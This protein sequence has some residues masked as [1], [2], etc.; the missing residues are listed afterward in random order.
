MK[1]AAPRFAVE[2]VFAACIGAFGLLLLLQPGNASTY[3]ALNDIGGTLPPLIAGGIAIAAS[4]ASRDKGRPGWLLIG[5]GCLS[6]GTGEAIWSWYEIVLNQDSPF[7]SVADAA[8]LGAVPLLFAGILVLTVPSSHSMRIRLGLDALAVVA[9]AGALSSHF[10]LGPIVDAASMTTLEK[11]LTS[12]YPL[13]DLALLFALVV[14][15]PR[16]MSNEAGR[17][18][19]VFGAGLVVFLAADSGFAYLET[20]ESYGTGS[21]VDIGWVIATTLF[22]YAAYLQLKTRAEY[23][24]ERPDTAAGDSWFQVLPILLLPVM[25]GWPLVQELQ[26]APLGPDEF[27]TLAFIFG[28]VVIVVMRQ[29]V[30][31]LDGV[32]LN[33]RLK[34]SNAKLEIRTEVLSERLVQEETAANI[35]WLT[36]ALSRRAIQA[37]MDRLTARIPATG[38]AIGI[39][40][41][42]SLKRINDRDGH[43]AGDEVL[44]AVAAALALEGAIVGRYGGDEFLILLPHATEEEILAYLSIV[45]W[46]LA[47]LAGHQN[48]D[49]PTISSGF[50]LY[51]REAHSPQGLI[52]LADQRMYA[53]KNHK[54]G[55]DGATLYRVA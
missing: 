17:V 12:A 50:A 37:E 11:L 40:D 22:A 10:V 3:Q 15:L 28:F 31:L 48:I 23:A 1:F 52:D 6:W 49:T 26:G 39:V 36:G 32:V 20:T 46:R 2:A 38:L 29:T 4:R 43:A 53:A 42:D 24:D 44:R 30:A 55:L 21:I 35:D 27:G 19:G 25:V 9:A 41:L 51:P 54:K 34:L 45:E 14:S 16:L 7:P 47:N 5:L 33:R 13:G 8:Y 18:L